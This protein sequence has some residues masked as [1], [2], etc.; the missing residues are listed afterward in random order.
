MK[1]F[2]SQDLTWVRCVGP[3][4][5]PAG[6][7]PGERLEFDILAAVFRNCV[8]QRC[9]CSESSARKMSGCEDRRGGNLGILRARGSGP[10]ST[11]WRS[12]SRKTHHTHRVNTAYKYTLGD[13]VFMTLSMVVLVNRIIVELYATRF[14]MMGSNNVYCTITQSKF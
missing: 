13:N 9:P 8:R 4:S 1:D 10:E 11:S 14:N 5:S 3:R 12:A 7:G 6:L 2:S